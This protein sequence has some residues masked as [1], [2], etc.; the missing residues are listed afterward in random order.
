MSH[1]PTRQTRFSLLRF[2]INIFIFC[3]CEEKFLWLNEKKTP[4]S[5]KIFSSRLY[6]KFNKS[7]S[8]ICEDEEMADGAKFILMQFHPISSLCWKTRKE[9]FHNF[10]AGG[11]HF[12]NKTHHNYNERCSPLKNNQN[13][14]IFNDQ[15]QCVIFKKKDSSFHELF[16]KKCRVLPWIINGIEKEWKKRRFDLSSL[17]LESLE[18]KKENIFI[19]TSSAILPHV[20]N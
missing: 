17:N 9:R 3:L 18:S 8:C 7:V 16:G 15:W 14:D 13:D 1:R 11:S 2:S 6:F 19:L 10:Y 4:A 12:S 20:W 5:D